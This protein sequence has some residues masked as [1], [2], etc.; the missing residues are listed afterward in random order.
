MAIAIDTTTDGGSSNPVASLTFSHTCNGNDR[1]LTVAVEG[2]LSTNNITGVTYNGVSMTQVGT[3]QNGNSGT[4]RYTYFFWLIA[5]AT[6]ANSVVVSS[7]PNG[8]IVA[9]SASYTGVKQTGQPDASNTGVYATPSP[10]LTLTSVLDNTWVIISSFGRTTGAA[11]TGSTLRVQNGTS[12]GGIY[13][14]G[15]S[16]SAGAQSLTV[17]YSGGVDAGNSVGA[18]FAPIPST[19]TPKVILF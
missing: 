15:A 2:D 8:F 1:L 4:T 11:G 9:V 16:V 5:P 7:S 14:S 13:D 3:G 6:G 18:S 10:A 19:F 12:G 17:T